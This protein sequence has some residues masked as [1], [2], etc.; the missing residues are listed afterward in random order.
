MNTNPNF[1]NIQLKQDFL[2]V[3]KGIFFF[4]F[5]RFNFCFARRYMHLTSQTT[6]I[7]WWGWT[8]EKLEIYGMKF[9]NQI[10]FCEFIMDSEMHKTV[11]FKENGDVFEISS[12]LFFQLLYS[13]K[14]FCRVFIQLK[15]ESEIDLVDRISDKIIVL[16]MN[17]MKSIVCIQNTNS[18]ISW[19]SSPDLISF[20]CIKRN[21]FILSLL[22]LWEK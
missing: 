7:F 21:R 16:N 12:T 20:I 4:V 13:C 15:R 18:C 22:Y 19:K 9:C 2:Y 3:D 6:D 5:F 8:Y 1:A 10:K 11:S 14:T 17:F